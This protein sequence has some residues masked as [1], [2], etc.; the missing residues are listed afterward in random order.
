MKEVI[1]TY[2]EKLDKIFDIKERKTR[3][4][5]KRDHRL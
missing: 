5:C 4:R 1:S 2:Q 3:F